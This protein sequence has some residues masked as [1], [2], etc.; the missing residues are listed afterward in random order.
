MMNREPREGRIFHY[1]DDGAM[2]TSVEWS[3]DLKHG[4]WKEWWPDGQIAE[5]GRCENGKQ[6]GVWRLWDRDG[7]RMPDNEYRD[8]TRWTGVWFR[9]RSADRGHLVRLAE[10]DRIREMNGEERFVCD[11]DAPFEREEWLNG[12]RHGE[13]ASWTFDGTKYKQDHYID[14]ERV[15]AARR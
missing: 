13:W 11:Y 10:A 3:N 12:K 14:G 5:E 9:M 1:Y 2:H 4:E 15:E 7:T 6:I 8:G